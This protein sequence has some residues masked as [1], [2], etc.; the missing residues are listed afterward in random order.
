MQRIS[1]KRYPVR[2]IEQ[3]RERLQNPKA[4]QSSDQK[5]EEQ[6]N[7]E[8]DQ[9]KSGAKQ[10]AV[11]PDLEDVLEEMKDNEES[12]E[13][14]ED[15]F[16]DDFAF[17]DFKSQPQEKQPIQPKIRSDRDMSLF[18][19]NREWVFERRCE[20]RETEEERRERRKRLFLDL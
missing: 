18:K 14:E 8:A 3:L 15:Y 9:M 7:K 13:V 12:E 2:G 16:D 10:M 19:R 1:A 6:G 5:E 11:D 4:F 20:I 17:M